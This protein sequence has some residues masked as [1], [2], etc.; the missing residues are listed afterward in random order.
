MRAAQTLTMVDLRNLQSEYQ[1]VGKGLR[2]FAVPEKYKRLMIW[3]PWS[4]RHAR[5][6]SYRH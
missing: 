6:L 5:Q 4:Q 1:L 3:W 2:A